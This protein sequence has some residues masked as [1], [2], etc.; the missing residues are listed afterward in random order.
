M[1]NRNGFTYIPLCAPVG[2]DGA[3][4]TPW[5]LDPTTGRC[6]VG[7]NVSAGKRPTENDWPNR[8]RAERPDGNAGILMGRDQGYLAFDVDSPANRKAYDSWGLPDT[9]THLTGNGR[10]YIFGWPEG[11]DRL[12]GNFDGVLVRGNGQI[13]APGSTHQNG[14]PY[15]VYLDR[16]AA[17]LPEEFVRKMLGVG[18]DVDLAAPAPRAPMAE[19]VAQGGRTEAVT[20]IAGSLRRIGAPEAAALAAAR[21]A[22]ENTF[23]PPLPDGKVAATVGGI[24]QRYEPSEELTPRAEMLSLVAPLATNGQHPNPAPPPRPAILARYAD[25]EFPVDALPPVVADWVEVTSRSLSV[26]PGLVGTAAW[27]V[28]GSA[29]GESRVLRPGD[30]V[31]R[32]IMWSGIIAGVSVRKTPT[33]GRAAAPLRRVQE[34]LDRDHDARVA[35]WKKDDPKGRGP[36]PTPMDLILDDYTTEALSGALVAHPRGILLIQD[37][38][39]GFIGAMGQYKNGGGA[40]RS[41]HLSLWAGDPWRTARIGRRA[42]IQHPHVSVV[43]GIQPDVIHRLLDGRD[44][45]GSRFLLCYQPRGRKHIADPVPIEL[46]Y[47]YNDVVE[48][49]YRLTPAQFPQKDG[50]VRLVPNELKWAAGALDA[51][52]KH[53]ERLYAEQADITLPGALG[54]YWGKLEMY[55]VRFCIVLTELW[56]VAE[57][58]E[59]AVT[60]DIVNAAAALVDYYKSQGVIVFETGVASPPERY[61]S[62]GPIHVQELVEVLKRLGGKATLRRVREFSRKLRCLAPHE[63]QK[64]LDDARLQ[65]SV[66]V[67]H[68]T[69][70]NKVQSIELTLLLNK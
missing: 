5:H 31:V 1:S 67:E 6:E 3:C 11:V 53:L 10:H 42:A 21:E 29:I 34:A 35:A 17:E 63:M 57:G 54:E 49:L 66:A 39:A 16:P 61:Q 56:H 45:L 58:H 37:E 46:T 23:D 59:E 40:D 62:A 14:K 48:D 70:P 19:R 60:V 13:V 15:S 69:S 50:G 55:L 38:L 47:R 20:R 2:T 24:Y 41:R 12:P 7:G 65:G 18:V 64:T 25:I 26:S 28:F 33:V 4:D 36:E 8:G 44:G 27:P 30:W 22:N 52:E 51:Y 43:G 9:L 68:K 32:P